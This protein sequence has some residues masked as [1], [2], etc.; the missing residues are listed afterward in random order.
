MH[1]YPLDAVSPIHQC[2]S[3]ADVMLVS[4]SRSSKQRRF[5]RA[6]GGNVLT[7]PAVCGASVL[8]L[9]LRGY[10]RLVLCV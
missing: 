8:T 7:G 6:C 1:V 2:E 5:N 9:A 10:F 4:A 3:Q